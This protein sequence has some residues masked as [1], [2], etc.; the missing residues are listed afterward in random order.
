MNDYY[1]KYNMK[2]TISRKPN[3]LYQIRVGSSETTR[4]KYYHILKMNDK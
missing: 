2:W 1:I 3:N 4:R